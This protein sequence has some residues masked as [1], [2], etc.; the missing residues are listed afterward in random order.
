M[1]HLELFNQFGYIDM[2]APARAREMD[3]DTS[4]EAAKWMNRSGKA[5]R[6]YERV[7]SALH[8]S[9]NSTAGEV[10]E[11]TGLGHVEA[12]RRLSD[13]LKARCVMK[14]AKR[15]CSVNQTNMVTWRLTQD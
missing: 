15:L 7:L 5:V 3:E 13:L 14:G 9:P 10:G 4:H 2:S 6:H 1:T 12:Q 8:A 11:L